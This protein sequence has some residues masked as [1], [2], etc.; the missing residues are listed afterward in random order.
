MLVALFFCRQFDEAVTKCYHLDD[1]CSTCFLKSFEAL[2]IS[3][4]IKYATARKI[5]HEIKATA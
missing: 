1:Q 4:F 2:I 5:M 3:H